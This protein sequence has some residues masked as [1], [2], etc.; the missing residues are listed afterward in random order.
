MFRNLSLKVKLISLCVALALIPVIILSGFALYKFQSFGQ[1]AISV[2]RKGLEAEAEKG[3]QASLAE[4]K[5]E[6]QAL[7]DRS[8]QVSRTLAGSVNLQSYLSS[9][10][11]RN[12]EL[13]RF[14]RREVAR[15]VNGL[16][17]AADSQQ[18]LLEEIFPGQDTGRS[19]V[20]EQAKATIID[21]V[22]RVDIG[23]D[24]YVF[25]LDSRGDTVA[26]PNPDNIG[27]NVIRDQGIDLFK[28]VLNEHSPSRN[29]FLNYTWKGRDKFIAY[30][31]FPEWD[32]IICASGFWDELTAEAATFSK[33]K[34][35]E[36]MR[37]TA[38]SSSIELKGTSAPLFRSI[39]FV[40]QEGIEELG[41][42]N[43]RLEEGNV[44]HQGTDWFEKALNLKAGEIFHSELFV[45]PETS[46]AEMVLATPVYSQGRPQG[47]LAVNLD[48]SLVWGLLSSYTFGET[49]YASVIND[50]GLIVS[51]PKY[52]LKDGVDLSSDRHGRLAELVQDEMLPGKTGIESYS[53]EGVEKYAAFKPLQLGSLTFPIMATSPVDEFLGAV[54]IMKTTAEELMRSSMTVIFIGAAIFALAGV[55]IAFVF[56]RSIA[57]AL[58]RIIAGL[59]SS[60]EQ[61]TS[62][63][64]QL[65]STSQQMAEGSSQQAS[66]LEETS[67]SLEEMSSQT[68]QNADNASQAERSM[69]EAGQVVHNGV[70]AMKRMLEA[71]KDIQSS[72]NETSKIIKT[73]DDIAFQTNLLALNAAVEAARAG[74]A[75]KG[76]AVVAEEVR[77]L[78][79]RS[80]E[81]ARNTSELIEH[82]Q[83]SADN[84]VTVAEDVSGSLEQIKESAEKVSTLV[85]EIAAASNEQAQGI[86]QVNTAVSEMDKVVQQNAADSE[87]SA[88]ASEE[89]SS[90]AHELN[91]M[92]AELMAVV[93]GSENGNG[94]IKRPALAPGFRQ[95]SQKQPG[96]KK[97]TARS[98]Q[99]NHSGVQSTRQP[100]RGQRPAASAEAPEQMIP[101]DENDFND[102]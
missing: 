44:S 58:N 91:A 54:Q 76:F 77:N 66:N 101:L 56:S 29:Q 3:L 15:V 4:A 100:E 35:Q 96:N 41:L 71:I 93:G 68:K 9:K 5:M 48:W 64:A 17:A 33:K 84:G 52:T 25:I 81:A 102:F 6:V 38:D 26:H 30:R 10:A 57:N 51:H 88:S 65:F 72:S 39:R 42:I 97:R 61:V 47:V 82:S 7:V 11:G 83:S 98:R 40:N 31:F 50:Q 12:E 27:Q 14:S 95:R 78:A 13:N 67:S 89:L 20:R 94:R 90:Q 85:A 92:V 63:S 79:Q 34:F 75:G 45:S 32:W 60:S 18:A 2:A 80:A 74:E 37:V 99:T 8:E 19:G 24:G 70:E 53:F 59:Q 73:I 23:Q 28:E 46:S 55:L 49:G 22:D 1:E 16:I 87:E 62:A 69:Q 86:S 43:G 21:Q 36:E